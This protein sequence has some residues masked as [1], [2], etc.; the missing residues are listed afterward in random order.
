M[1]GN[2]V[3][4]PRELRLA[5]ERSSPSRRA[6]GRG[7]RKK[8]S[9]ESRE[10]NHR[11]MQIQT[12][13]REAGV[14]GQKELVET[15]ATLTK[16]S[17]AEVLSS[18]KQDEGWTKRVGIKCFKP[19]IYK[20][21]LCVHLLISPERVAERNMQKERT[22]VAARS[23]CF[24]VRHGGAHLADAVN[25]GIDRIAVALAVELCVFLR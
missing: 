22:A 5:S 16:S 3:F 11:K 17:I 21:F 2:A 8:V 18:V 24:S 1:P 20:A 15:S 7:K 23:F 4:A 13:R 9:D 6:S 10:S 19:L 14:I 25:F 12:S